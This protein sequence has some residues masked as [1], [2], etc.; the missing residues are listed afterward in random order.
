MIS[1]PILNPDGTTLVPAPY[2]INPPGGFIDAVTLPTTGVY[3]IVGD[4]LWTYT[5]AVTLTLYDV[6]DLTGTITAG[7]PAVTVTTT[8]PGQNARLTVSGTT[9]QRVSLLL[10]NV[11]ITLTDV[12]IVKPD[13]TTLATTAV[14]TSGG[15][16]DTQTLPATGPYTVLVDPRTSNTGSLTLTLYTVPADVATTITAG[17][18]AVTVTLSTPGQNGALTFSGTT[19]QRIS[20]RLTSVTIAVGFVSIKNPDGTALVAPTFVGTAG[21]FIVEGLRA[22]GC[23]APGRAAHDPPPECDRRPDDPAWLVRGKPA[24]AEAGRG[25]LRVG[26]DDRAVPQDAPPGRPPRWLDVHLRAGGLQHGADPGPDP[27]AGAG[28]TGRR[29]PNG[30]SWQGPDEGSVPRDSLQIV[31]GTGR[32]MLNP[33]S[34]NTPWATGEFEATFQSWWSS[35]KSQS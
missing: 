26:E 32:S 3:T 7:G 30:S 11:S 22:L 2:G 13:A 16:I 28:M 24:E 34:A 35:V 17:G 14:S 10:T 12:S 20:L 23:H 5:G 1:V 15:F 31:S 8:V 6:A 29:G 33:R 25:D 9:G 21:G 4:P 18:A 27:G 19:G